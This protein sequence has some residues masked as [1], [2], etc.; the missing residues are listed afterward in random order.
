MLI[1]NQAE[2]R[3]FNMENVVSLT[4]EPR[5]GKSGATVWKIIAS[6]V[7]DIAFLGTYET[8]AEAK[9]AFLS[10]IKEYDNGRSVITTPESTYEH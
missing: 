6:L 5:K 1:L 8:Q 9:D 10:I 3:A 4:Y 7:N 2:Y